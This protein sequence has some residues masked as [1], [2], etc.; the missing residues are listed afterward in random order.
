VQTGV[1]FTLDDLDK[2]VYLFLVRQIHAKSDIVRAG[3]EIM[4][5]KGFSATGV[6]AILKQANVC[7]GSFYNFFSSK[8]EFGLA[9]IDEFRAKMGAI[10]QPIAEDTS[11]P[12]LARLRKYFETVFG[13]FERDNCTKGCLFGNLG[14]EMADQS[15]AVRER[16]D[17][18]LQLWTDKICGLLEEAQDAR[19]LPADLDPRLMAETLVSSFEGALLL[20]KVKKSP[21]PLR[22]FIAFYFERVL[23]M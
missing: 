4:L 15:E 6:E 22:S 21:Q 11:L 14:L 7:K 8:E 12:P 18:G 9:V 1:Q 5:R 2:P 17:Y 20:A 13:M 23:T 16:I 3:M 10:F 19:Q